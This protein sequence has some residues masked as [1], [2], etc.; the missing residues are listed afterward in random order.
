MLAPIN[1]TENS[2]TCFPANFPPLSN[3]SNFGMNLILLIIIPK[4]NPTN[5]ESINDTLSNLIN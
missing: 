5:K 4:S 1:M 3:D 2:R